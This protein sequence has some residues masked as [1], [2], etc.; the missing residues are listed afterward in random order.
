M[1]RIERAPL[2]SHSSGRKKKPSR[3]RRGVAADDLVTGDPLTVPRLPKSGTAPRSTLYK[4][5]P[6]APVFVPAVAMT[7]TTLNAEN[8][9][10][11]R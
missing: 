2:P 3:R 9:R 11:Q 8:Q 4:P 5:N 6:D 10:E 1:E 7:S